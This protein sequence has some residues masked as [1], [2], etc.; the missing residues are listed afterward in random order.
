MGSSNN[1]AIDI[2]N[3]FFEG[4]GMSSSELPYPTLPYPTL[5]YPTLPY[6]TLPYLTTSQKREMLRDTQKHKNISKKSLHWNMRPL[7]K[8]LSWALTS[9]SLRC[10]GVLCV[11]SRCTSMNCWSHSTKLCYR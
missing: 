8:V 4:E 2:E 3:A 11:L 10:A 7:L 5:P 6:P 1:A 9:S